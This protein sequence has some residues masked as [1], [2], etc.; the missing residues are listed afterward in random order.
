MERRRKIA[1]IGAGAWG[2]AFS[3]YLS[4]KH[5]DI[6]LWVFEEELY[7]YMKDHRTN[8]FYLPDFPIPENVEFTH[9]LSEALEFSQDIVCALPSFAVEETFRS[10]SE[11]LSGKKI[12]IL[13]KGLEPRKKMRISEIFESLFGDRIT[14]ASLSGPSFAKEVAEG[15]FTSVVVSSKQKETMKYFQGLLHDPLFRVYS[16]ED[17]IGVEL[18]GALKNVM[19]IGAGII[20]GLNMGMNTISAYI[21]RAIAE[22]KRL[23]KR[24]GAKETTFM[25]LSGMGDLILTCFGPLSRN[26]AFGIEL[27]RGKKS[28]DILSSKKVVFE[29]YHTLKAAFE[30]SKS[31][32]VEMP[33]VNEL[34]QVI[35]EGKD[36][37]RSI[38]EIKERAFKEED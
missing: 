28:E 16:C 23:G 24:M 21:T 9:S 22:M 10:F 20:E 34:Y 36:I 12:L 19:A 13:T 4:K 38:K 18:G 27:A 8:P 29:G 11:R 33:I 2:T 6:L 1:I 35:Y 17:L 37:S 15:R 25:G 14:Y 26:R 31:L 3:L 30:L 5:F 32:N 7:K